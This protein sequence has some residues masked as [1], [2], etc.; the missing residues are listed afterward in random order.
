[1]QRRGFIALLGGLAA[2]P[3]LAR[4]QGSGATATV[5]ILMPGAEGD[6]SRVERLNAFEAA[7]EKL[8]WTAGKNL[9]IE[10]RWGGNDPAQF[11]KQATE[12]V[13]SRP[14]VIFCD[15]TIALRALQQQTNSIPIVFATVADPVGQ[16]FVSSLAQPG[17][18]I[19]G[20]STLDPALVGK[21]PELL[22]NI[23][24]PIDRASV[25]YNPATM[26]YAGQ[27]IG[28]I[29][30]A[31]QQVRLPVRAVAVGDVAAIEVEAA[32]MARQSHSALMVLPGSFSVSNR[33]EIIRIAAQYRLPAI[34]FFTYFATDGGL[35]AYGS[36]GPDLHRRAAGYVDRVLRG[37]KPS[38]LPVQQPIKFDLVV[39]LKTAKQLGIT[40]AP[41]LLATADVVIE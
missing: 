26:P 36:N 11:A 16:G 41:A 5:S 24:P 17:G 32:A 15:G 21:W 13:R 2:W 28:A 33:A 3:V 20:F 30:Q 25:L 23:V 40:I 22:K 39:N 12:L 37:A 10:I 4:G 18:N 9:R 14:T 19:T 1:M 38:D 29:E 35:M 7:L 27:M 31:A 34:Y 8:G 6:A